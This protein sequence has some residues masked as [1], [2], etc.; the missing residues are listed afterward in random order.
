MPTGR[1]LII[2]P[3]LRLQNIY[4]NLAADA[5]LE[6]T[7]AR[8]ADQ[9]GVLITTGRPPALMLINLSL[10]GGDAFAVIRVLRGRAS[11][12]ECPVVVVSGFAELRS[13]ALRLREELG[14]TEIMSTTFSAEAAGVTIRRAMVRPGSFATPPVET[15][16]SGAAGSSGSRTP[17]PMPAP[18]AAPARLPEILRE[19][20]RLARLAAMRLVEDQPSDEL[21]QK[22]VADVASAFRVPMALVS[23]SL[24]ER[25][26]F[27]AH[28]GMSGP[29]VAPDGI[30]AP[31]TLS[32][33][34]Q[35]MFSRLIVMQ[36]KPPQELEFLRHVIDADRPEPLLVSDAR[37]HPLFASNPLVR[38]GLIGSL[39]AAPLVTP[40]GDTLGTLSILDTKPY[41]L[42]ADA[43][44][45]LIALARRVAGEL[46][47]QSEKRQFEVETSRLRELRAM[48][49]E[50]V[51]DLRAVVDAMDAGVL[52]MDN[53]RRIL[54][55]NSALSS[56]LGVS[57]ESIIGFEHQA[58]LEAIASQFAN[59]E[60]F[61][62]QLRAPE[63]GAYV[64]REEIELVQ[65]E[66]RFLRWTCRPV[67][68]RSCEGQLSMFTDVTAER[69]LAVLQERLATTDAL[70]GIANRRGAEEALQREVSR[71]ARESAPIGLI[72]ADLDGFSR[73]NATHGHELGD[74]VLVE[75]AR[76]LRA[77]F[78]PYDTVARW[79]GE[80]F[81]ILLPSTFEEH[82]LMCAERMRAAM[83]SLSV[84]GERIT[85]SAGVTVKHRQEQVKDALDRA[86]SNLQ[87]AKEAG[88]NRVV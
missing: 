21:L 83:E 69:E 44:D 25:Q 7:T 5:G 42:S 23:L 33:D 86:R 85:I 77:S 61:L 2:E 11:A 75:V 87:R 53:E 29:G 19:K 14:I 67:R 72:M 70:T 36:E 22:L 26:W 31:P 82:T 16:D 65:P 73:I 4:R 9:A 57:P 84:A 43:T 3:N 54:L 32:L 37:K 30:S 27:K 28:F 46:E 13:A 76:R 24:G 1:A 63:S 60:V 80:M 39:A 38:A 15:I 71:A 55:A 41:A 17:T 47:M 74:R 49:E 20:S 59:P 88:R 8:D 51:T 68:L 81:L 66:R 56:M 18:M 79:G 40:G 64:G 45:L 52:V 6:P 62:S 34:G 50:A 78:R 35:A 10:P 48:H 58:F 12:A